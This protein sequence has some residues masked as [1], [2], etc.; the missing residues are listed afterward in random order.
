ME[1]GSR[2]L[3][4]NGFSRCE[5]QACIHDRISQ[6]SQE[7]VAT[8]ITRSWSVRTLKLSVLVSCLRSTYIPRSTPNLWWTPADTLWRW[9]RESLVRGHRH[10]W[11][12]YHALNNILVPHV[13]LFH[14]RLGLQCTGS[15]TPTQT[16]GWKDLL[17]EY[18]TLGFLYW[19]LPV[20]SSCGEGMTETA[21]VCGQPP[22]W[23]LVV[24]VLRYEQLRMFEEG[25]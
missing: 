17:G 11:S 24:V 16:G 12:V 21:P 5:E 14:P 7:L 10:N 2:W 20:S 22:T 6:K 18:Y 13:P 3:C 1:A 9:W 19:N 8:D 15:K 4:G 23:F 25:L